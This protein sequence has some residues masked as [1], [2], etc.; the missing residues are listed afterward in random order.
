MV[1]GLFTLLFFESAMRTGLIPVNTQYTAFFTHSPLAMRITDRSGKIVLSSAS[2]A[3][4]DDS[5]IASALMSYP[6]PWHPDENTLLYAT[7]IA[8][9]NAL[10]QEDITGLNRLHAEVEESIRSLTAANTFLAE[11]ER[12]K[13]AIAEEAEKTRLMTELETE[14]SGHTARLSSMIE[15][16]DSTAGQTKDRIVLSLLLCYIK[17]Q[18]NLFF[19]Q[20]EDDNIPFR[21]LVSTLTN[22]L[23]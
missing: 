17:R 9:G 2:D 3:K 23:I 13:R 1:T 5:A 18:S 8:G 19:R 21:E 20:R 14:I 12:I 7:G 11:E 15:Q 6:L 22:W 4:Y 16:L 10:W